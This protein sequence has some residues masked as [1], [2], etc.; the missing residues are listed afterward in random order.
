MKKRFLAIL[1]TVVMVLALAVPASAAVT[2]KETKLDQVW[3][4]NTYEANNGTIAAPTAIASKLVKTQHGNLYGYVNYQDQ[5]IVQEKYTKLNDFSEGLALAEKDGSVV[6]VDMTGK[7]VITVGNCKEAHDFKQGL[8]RIVSPTGI[9]YFID[10]TGKSVFTCGNNTAED[11]Q[12]VGLARVTTP[13]GKIGLVNTKGQEVTH[14]WF[15][16]IRPYSENLA[17]A[18]IGSREAGN[19]RQ[20]FLN[21]YGYTAFEVSNTLK[22]GADVTVGG[23]HSDFSNGMVIVDNAN[24]FKPNQ[25]SEARIGYLDTTGYQAVH[26]QFEQGDDFAGN[27]ARIKRDGKWGYVGKNNLYTVQP[28]YD[29]LDRGTG[30][31]RAMQNKR[32]TITNG[33]TIGL[34]GNH[35]VVTNGTTVTAPYEHWGFV[36]VQNG[37]VVVPLIY[38]N[39]RA[40]TADNLAYVEQDYAYSHTVNKDVAVR[41]DS[42]NVNKGFVNTTGT[43]VVNAGTYYD[44]IGNS[45]EGKAWVAK[46]GKW[47]YIGTT[48]GGNLVIPMVYDV[49]GVKGYPALTGY[50]NFKNGVAVACWGNVHASTD[51]GDDVGRYGVINANGTWLTTNGYTWID[52]MVYAD[53]VAL[54]RFGGTEEKIRFV[55][56]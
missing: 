53:R 46:N 56:Y 15:D 26:C 3:H 27:V 9:T 54:A 51:K 35:V 16:E 36:N 31:V 49:D 41:S 22:V 8:A 50:A 21:V 29:A 42:A 55:F 14:F 34:E 37:T 10:K 30:I 45:Y 38:T 19:L 47:G 20:F 6:Y 43:L 25:E 18:R 48:T 5:I 11:F 44:Q 23:S 33:P 12:S 40:F 52:Y 28:I 7:E 13:A 2:A 17:Y 4:Y 39:A 32:D 1:L 24:T